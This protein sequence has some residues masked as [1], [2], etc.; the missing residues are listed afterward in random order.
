MPAGAV[1]AALVN[2]VDPAL[3]LRPVICH[4]TEVA[5]L[6]IEGV[7]G[8][9]EV[10]PGPHNI[11][12]LVNLL[13]PI[14]VA[15]LLGSFLDVRLEAVNQVIMVGEQLVRQGSVTVFIE[16]PLDDLH[17]LLSVMG[18]NIAVIIVTHC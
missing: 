7:S 16:E 6:T 4:Q 17:G 5:H 13:E 18:L 10:S 14:W 9:L 15:F 8:Q 3:E 12:H 2:L 1:A 11:S